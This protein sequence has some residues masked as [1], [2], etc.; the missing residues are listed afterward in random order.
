MTCAAVT[1]PTYVVKLDGFLPLTL[2]CA[3]RKC[4]KIFVPSIPCHINVSHGIVFVSFHD[5]FDVTNAS[6][7][8]FTRICGSAAL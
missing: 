6:T 8:L 1:L 7:P 4:E 3:V 2:V 5:I